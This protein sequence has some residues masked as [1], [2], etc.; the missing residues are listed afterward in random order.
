MEGKNLGRGIERSGRGRGGE[1]RRKSFDCRLA[2]FLERMKK[3]TLITKRG[4]DG[5]DK[6]LDISITARDDDDE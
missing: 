6:S 1:G 5:V 4:I 2:D 3:K